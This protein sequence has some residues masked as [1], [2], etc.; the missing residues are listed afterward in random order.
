MVQSLYRK[1]RPQTFDEVI[2]QEHVEQT[3]QNALANN[4]IS[5][6]YLF[7]GPRGT[8]KTTTARVLAK[9]LLCEKGPTATPDGT[10]RDCSDI[11]VGV[12]PDVYELDAASRTGV[13]NVREEII[14]RVAYAPTR[15][16]YKVYI[17]D[18]VHMLST[19]A[20]NALLKTLE[21]PPSHVVFIL[22]TTDPQKVPPTI[23]SRCQRFDFHRLSTEEICRCLVTI[24]ESENFT[25]DPAAIELIARQASGGMRDAITALEQVAVF[26][27][28]DVRLE[29]AENLLGDTGVDQLFEITDFICHHDVAGCFTWV[30]SFLQGGIDI[31]HFVR[32]LTAH[33]RNL[34]VVALT[35]SRVGLPALDD[36]HYDRLKMQATQFDDAD[37][38]ARLLVILGDLGSELRAAAD[39]RL[40]L[41]IALVRMARPDA[42]WTLEGL[43]ERLT[44]LEQQLSS[45]GG[46]QMMTSRDSRHP[47]QSA[48][49]SGEKP[50]Q[51]SDSGVVCAASPVKRKAP[52]E[53]DVSPVQRGLIGHSTS[54]TSAEV[55]RAFRQIVSGVKE[56]R[57]S[58]AALFGGAIPHLDSA[59]S[60]LTIELP[61]AA[62][63]ALK[64]L[65]RQDNASMVLGLARLVFDENIKIV[66]VLSNTSDSVETMPRHDSEHPST[67]PHDMDPQPLDLLSTVDAS[68]NTLG[69]SSAHSTNNLLTGSFDDILSASFGEG[70]VFEEVKD[71]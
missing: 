53:R 21:E 40:V 2:G 9:S 20:F 31:T 30:A 13:E 49:S 62:L 19:A 66:Y 27:S 14:S 39:A 6:A 42:D 11:A 28:G 46:S 47:Q 52:A 25:Y 68:M 24:C 1:Y 50:L 38:I 3:L 7:C 5:H 35:D 65:E 37:G 23:I 59:Q 55:Q 43:A 36:A 71:S 56:Q 17:I 4:V 64:Q 45:D 58:V 15:G 44:R 61:Q 18:E 16:S 63:F 10:C 67:S 33:V 57:P 48:P 69:D 70:V 34:Y 60:T 22:C 8:G 29:A 26:G 12:H 32:N 51:S 54:T 41:E